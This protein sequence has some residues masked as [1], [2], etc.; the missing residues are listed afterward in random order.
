M[1]TEDLAIQRL[2]GKFW[3]DRFSELEGESYRGGPNEES[4]L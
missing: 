1:A 4:L 2:G 3:S